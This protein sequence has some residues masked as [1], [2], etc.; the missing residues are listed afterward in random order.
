V[1]F[2]VERERWRH[3][4]GALEGRFRGRRPGLPGN[5]NLNLS[6][7]YDVQG[8]DARCRD[9]SDRSSGGCQSAKLTQGDY[10]KSHISGVA[11]LGIIV[12]VGIVIGIRQCAYITQS[13]YRNDWIA[14]NECSERVFAGRD[15]ADEAG[16]G[17][18]AS[19]AAIATIRRNVGACPICKQQLAIN[20][21]I[22]A[23]K[24]ADIERPTIVV[25]CPSMHQYQGGDRKG[26][27]GMTNCYEARLLPESDL[28]P[29]VT[30]EN[31]PSR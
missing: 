20:P 7:K 24:R 16:P 13:Q 25:C 6:E 17:Q 14:F 15:V 2:A 29:W 9:E 8:P 30:S 27:W 22:G 4:S 19:S 31:S 1:K 26:Y 23:W 28:P 10:M 21:D 18:E 3:D 11:L 12:I 5:Q